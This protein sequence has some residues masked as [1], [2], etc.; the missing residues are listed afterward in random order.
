VENKL[1]R[2]YKSRTSLLAALG[3][4]EFEDYAIA[5]WKI[6]SESYEGDHEEHES[7]AVE[8]GETGKAQPPEGTAQGVDQDEATKS[9][10]PTSRPPANTEA[11]LS[12]ALHDIQIVLDSLFCMN[13]AI[14][15]MR[16][17]YRL[18]LESA[19][20]ESVALTSP[21]LVASEQ[22]VQLPQSER[23]KEAVKLR[24]V[25]KDKVAQRFMMEE[26]VRLTKLLENAL[27][28]DE[29]EAAESED[30]EATKHMR[31]L[32]PVMK[33]HRLGLEKFQESATS[34]P[35][36]KVRAVWELNRTLRDT[37]DA[38]MLPK[39]MEGLD[40]TVWQGQPSEGTDKILDQALERI[41]NNI[42]MLY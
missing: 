1:R 9:E 15:S 26:S 28:N 2:F 31:L 38:V 24:V 20:D 37:V 40:T 10:V 36:E 21:T 33:N 22:Q 16:Q 23:L 6:L 13:S 29:A 19:M 5:R 7:K 8:V 17:S 14:R 27:R 32:S 25:S 3:A 39:D 18:N 34:M 35:P 42:T 41:G 11:M 4:G 30:P 12:S